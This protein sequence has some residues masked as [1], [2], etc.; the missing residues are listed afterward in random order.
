MALDRVKSSQKLIGIVG[1]IQ[2]MFHCEHWVTYPFMI[3]LSL[4]TNLK[5]ILQWLGDLGEYLDDIYMYYDK[6]HFAK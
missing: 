1:G 3:S 5:F 2:F 4:L 6:N